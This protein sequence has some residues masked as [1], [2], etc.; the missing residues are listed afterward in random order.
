M[1]SSVC[2]KPGRPLPPA[3]ARRAT[4]ELIELEIIRSLGGRSLI[5][6]GKT[7]FLFVCLLAV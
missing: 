4:L 6:L 7:S 1:D 3:T 5:F 2:V